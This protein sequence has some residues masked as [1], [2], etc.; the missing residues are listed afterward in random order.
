[1]NNAVLFL[2]AVVM[3]VGSVNGQV[4]I[5]DSNWPYGS[6]Q[7]GNFWDYHNTAS[8]IAV[9]M[10]T[11]NPMQINGSWNF[12]T[13][14][15]NSSASSE[16]RAVADAP[17]PAPAQ[18]TFVEYQT[19][20]GSSQW[21]YEAETG[22]GIVAR[23]VWQ[24]GTIYAYNSP[25]WNVYR[26]PMTMGTAWSSS[27]T[28]GEEALGTPIQETRNSEIVGWGTVTVPFGGPMPCLVMRTLQTSYAEYLGI[29]ILDET[30]RV[31]EWIVPDIGSVAAILSQEGETNWLFNTASAYFRLENTNLGGDLLSPSITAVTNLQDTPNPGPYN[32]NATITDSSGVES[33]L[34][35]YSTNGG[36]YS[37]AAPTNVDGSAY[38]FQIPMRTGSPVQEV[39]YYVWARDSAANMNVATNPADAPTSYYSFSWINDNLPP[40]I[41]NVTVWPSPTNFNGPYPV[42]ATITDDNG[43]LFASLHYRFG[44]GAWQESPADGNVGSVYSFTIP[45]ISATTIVRY[46]LEAVDNSGFF[47]TGFF[48]AAGQAGPI[49]FQAV[50]TVPANPRAVDDLTVVISGSDAVL[51]W[52]DVTQD[53][54]NNPTVIDHYD[55]YRGS[56]GDGS[57]F[58]LIGST[59]TSDFTDTG[60]VAGDPAHQYMIIAVQP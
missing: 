23:G 55:V 57:D 40:S 1:M 9:N 50:F 16:I 60:I 34:I 30:Y 28:W 13:G 6:D 2:F 18:T 56:V 43:I 5:D 25:Q 33:A 52:S 59:P 17:Q 8:S 7:I 37:S 58:T 36:A 19:Q 46:Y 53:V 35:Y 54:N 29:P 32:V 4:T 41:S 49:V 31:Y 51:R 22:L 42:S 44:G 14:P 39:R 38:S 11:I 20:G 24:G 48:P 45:S 12:S 3:Y 47:N 10:A 21:F 15:T 26:Y 27:W